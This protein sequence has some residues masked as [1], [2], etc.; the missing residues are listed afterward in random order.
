MVEEKWE[1]LYINGNNNGITTLFGKNVFHYA[2]PNPTRQ[3]NPLVL[4]LSLFLML[5]Y[6]SILSNISFW[7]TEYRSCMKHK[8]KERS[9]Q[10][11]SVTIVFRPPYATAEPF[12]LYILFNHQHT[13]IYSQIVVEILEYTQH[14]TI[15]S[16]IHG[17]KV[18]KWKR[19]KL[20]WNQRWGR[21]Q[22]QGERQR[23]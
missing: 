12:I 5:F 9:A 13:T 7:Y 21:Q 16:E 15:L 1:D 22:Q 4:L 23:Q 19:K 11:S 3:R 18:K 2:I 20:R 6:H 17:K 10:L 14:Y 8:R